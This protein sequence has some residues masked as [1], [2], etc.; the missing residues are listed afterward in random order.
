MAELNYRHLFSDIAESFKFT[1]Y[2]KKSQ[3]WDECTRQTIHCKCS[4]QEH[5][6]MFVWKYN[7]QL[8][9]GGTPLTVAILGIEMSHKYPKRY[10]RTLMRQ[11]SGELRLTAS[12]MLT[13]L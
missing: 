3:T 10:Q 6:H 5:P 13:Q 8:F 12:I 4:F 11:M 9:C 1:D 7:F 2:K